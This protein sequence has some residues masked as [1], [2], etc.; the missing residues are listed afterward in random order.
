M[1][2][3]E[4][5]ATSIKLKTSEVTKRPKVVPVIGDEH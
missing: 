5:A 4:Y 1:A 3:W 2:S